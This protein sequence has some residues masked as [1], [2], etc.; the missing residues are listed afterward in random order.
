M[1]EAL[2]ELLEQPEA[3]RDGDGPEDVTGQGGESQGGQ[4]EGGDREDGEPEGR[5]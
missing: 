4:S 5:A 1:D 3:P 2:A